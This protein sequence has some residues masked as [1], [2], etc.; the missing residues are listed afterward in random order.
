M[1]RL[2]ARPCPVCKVPGFFDDDE[3]RCF[4]CGS[5]RL[6]PDLCSLTCACRDTPWACAHE[7]AEHKAGACDICLGTLTWDECCALDIGGEPLD[8]ES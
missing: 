7:I 8:G 1:T 3:G 2:S 4:A 6:P 5:F